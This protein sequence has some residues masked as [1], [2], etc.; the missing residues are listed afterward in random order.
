MWFSIFGK[1]IDD[2]RLKKAKQLGIDFTINV[3]NKD[4]KTVKDEI[5]NAFDKQFA[6]AS[7]EWYVWL[8]Y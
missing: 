7:I 3:K 5:L 6:D 4:E 2:S 1:D 8:W